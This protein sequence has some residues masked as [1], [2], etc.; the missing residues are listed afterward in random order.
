METRYAIRHK[1][2]P[3]YWSSKYG[4]THISLADFFAALPEAREDGE[5]TTILTGS[6][7]RPA[8]DIE[9]LENAIRALQKYNK[10]LVDAPAASIR[11]MILQRA[12]LLEQEEGVYLATAGFVITRYKTAHEDFA[13][14]ISVSASLFSEATS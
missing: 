12:A 3:L 6:I 9:E 1:S 7:R 4:W 2:L 10:Y 11:E 5:P 14:K 13:F 8:I